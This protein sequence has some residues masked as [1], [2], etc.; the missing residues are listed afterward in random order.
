M[1]APHTTARRMPPVRVGHRAYFTKPDG[2]IGFGRFVQ[3]H[4]TYTNIAIVRAPDGRRVA[5]HRANLLTHREAVA[6]QR[7]RLGWTS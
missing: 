5:I 6:T 3:R 2:S 4:E 7:R 1:N